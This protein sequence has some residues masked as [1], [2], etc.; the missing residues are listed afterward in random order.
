MTMFFHKDEP[1]ER[2]GDR[3]LEATW[4]AFPGLAR[5][6][7]AL[8]WVVYDPPIEF[9]DDPVTL[10]R[11]PGKGQYGLRTSDYAYYHWT[12]EAEPAWVRAD[13]RRLEQVVVRGDGAGHEARGALAHEAGHLLE[14][15]RRQPERNQGVLHG[16]EKVL[17]G[18]H[19]R[20]VE[21]EDGE[22]RHYFA[23]PFWPSPPSFSRRMVNST[24]RFLARPSAVA[25]L[26]TGRLKP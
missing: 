9:G 7:I 11:L 26:A 18:V 4:A 17:A 3:I 25:L 19:E 14:R 20:P 24:R 22:P 1:L 10:F 6:Q 12:G 15:A 23:G 21:V 16:A 8:T 2:V 13:G 5:N